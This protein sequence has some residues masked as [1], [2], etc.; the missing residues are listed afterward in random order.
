MPHQG[1]MLKR[2]VVFIYPLL[3]TITDMNSL[4]TSQGPLQCQ[5]FPGE[6]D[7]QLTTDSMS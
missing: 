4:P 3:G 5:V 2:A 1:T 7:L 6:N